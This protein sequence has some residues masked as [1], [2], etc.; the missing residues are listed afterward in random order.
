MAK[1]S[2]EIEWEAEEYVVQDHNTIWFIL[3][4]IVTVILCGLTIW[5][6]NWTFLAVI[7]VAVFAILVR[8]FMPPRKI[9]YSMTEDTIIEGG[10][11]H[12]FSEFKSFAILKEG[13][14]YSAILMP[15]K[16][17]A[18]QLK[19]Y[20]P[21]KNGEEIVDTLGAKLPMVEAKLDFLDKLVKFLRI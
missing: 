8:V 11:I 18:L 5:F 19:V 21:E 20:F 6:Q 16:R 3:L 14:H 7:V 2:Q 9:H 15:K 4:G 12:N 17:L 1:N 10:N 13:T